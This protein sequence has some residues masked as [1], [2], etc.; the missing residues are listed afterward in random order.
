MKAMVLFG[1]PPEEYYAYDISKF[2]DE[3]SAPVAA[4]ERPMNWRRCCPAGF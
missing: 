1:I 3:P 2:D 4:S